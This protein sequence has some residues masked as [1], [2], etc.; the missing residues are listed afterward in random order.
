MLKENRN[1]EKE[2]ADLK[3]DLLERIVK[4]NKDTGMFINDLWLDVRDDDEK[5]YDDIYL[6]FEI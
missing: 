2:V 4:F 5:K 3:F 1:F 6:W